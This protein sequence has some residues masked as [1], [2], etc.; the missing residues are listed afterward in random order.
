MPEYVNGDKG[1]INQI[2]MNLAGNAIKFTEDGEVTISVKKTA[3][4]ADYYTLKFSVK[5]TGIGIPEDKLETIFD[6]FTQAEISTTRK[7]G[8]T[9][10]GLSIVKQLVEL[11]NGQIQVKSKIGRGSEFYFSLDFKKVDSAIVEMI[12]ENHTNRKS[13]GKLSILLCEDNILNQKL[14][15]NVIEKFGFDLDIANNGQ[16]GIDLLLKNE[17]DLILMDLQMPVK[18]G[19]QTTISIRKELKLDIPIIAMTAHS[20][21]GEQQKCFDIGMNG[22]VAKPFKQQELLD[23]IQTVMDS[24]PKDYLFNDNLSTRNVDF[25]YLD[26]LSGGNVDFRDEMID[27]FVHKIPNDLDLLEQLVDDENYANIK[28]LTHD[29]KPSLS[30]FQLT[31]EVNYLEQLE[32]SAKNQSI[33]AEVKKKFGAF[34][35]ELLDIIDLFEDK[36]Y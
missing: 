26:E 12:R 24:R 21:V 7:F 1:R 23:R 2:I 30:M 31:K 16:E 18:D 32:N 13:M 9:G 10:L 28:R 33:S 25:S 14:A 36:N 19:Y 27:L 35:Q 20:L 11:Q 29:M 4:T 3:E 6:R 5:D 34:K 17:Y 22:Y 8:G 15:R